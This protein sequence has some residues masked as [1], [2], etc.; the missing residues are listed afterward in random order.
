MFRRF[1]FF[2]KCLFRMAFALVVDAF[3]YIILSKGVGSSIINFAKECGFYGWYFWPIVVILA[4][5]ALVCEY[6]WAVGYFSGE[7][8][9]FKGHEERAA[10]KAAKEREREREQ[11]ERDREWEAERERRNAEY[12]REEAR[13]K[14]EFEEQCEQQRISSEAEGEAYVLIHQSEWNDWDF[15]KAEKVLRNLENGQLIRELRAKMTEESLRK[16]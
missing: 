5:V 13:R 14:K 9:S 6:L 7:N 2:L 3:V 1:L 16:R 12:E 11:E 15:P 8:Q 10:K 4:I